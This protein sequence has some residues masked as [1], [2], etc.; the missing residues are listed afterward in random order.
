MGLDPEGVGQVGRTTKVDKE[1]LIEMRASP[2]IK[3]LMSLKESQ[4]MVGSL[5]DV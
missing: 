5:L 1:E 3:N 4:K 2:I